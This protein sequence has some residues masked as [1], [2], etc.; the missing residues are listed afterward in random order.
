[1]ATKPSAQKTAPKPPARSQVP[2]RVQTSP[3]QPSREVVE[4]KPAGLPANVA[5][6]AAQFAGMGISD[7]MEDNIVPLVYLLQANSKAALKGH[8]R[9]VQGAVGGSIWLRNDS[10]ETALIDGEDG[11][12]FQPCHLSVCWIEWMPDRDGFVARHQYRP[13][14]AVLEDRERDDGTITK[15]WVM[16]SGNTVNESREYSGFVHRDGM[17]PAPYIIPL[18]GSGHSV[19]KAWMT[20]MRNEKLPNGERAPLFANLYRLRT[21]L[22][23]KNDYS[24]YQFDITKESPVEHVEDIMRGAQLWKDM[25]SGMKTAATIE[26]EAGLAEAGT[27]N[28]RVD[29]SRADD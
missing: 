16:P 7:R 3:K 10:P 5:E 24:W 15:V 6:A 20:S 8:E 4:T 27:G 13:E 14:E 26:D 12:L 25:Q 9:Y 23:T 28:D 17:D 11:M 2:A 19:G 22:R 29:D 1:M 21:K 18:S